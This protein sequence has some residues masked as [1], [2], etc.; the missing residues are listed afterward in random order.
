MKL[1]AAKAQLAEVQALERQ[2]KKTKKER[3]EALRKEREV[4]RKKAVAER[5]KRER[6]EKQAHDEL[7][8]RDQEDMAAA[9]H[10]N[11][12]MAKREERERE[13]LSHYDGRGVAMDYDPD[14]LGGTE[15]KNTMCPICMDDFEPGQ[16]VWRLHCSHAGC[17]VCFEGRKGPPSPHLWPPPLVLLQKQQG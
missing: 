1:D 10:H 6:A 3:D 17:D 4:E 13:V 9:V 2:E 14:G 8:L 11:V 7:L 16:R 15:I 5:K 12:Q